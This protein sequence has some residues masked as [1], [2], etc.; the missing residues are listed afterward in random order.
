MNAKRF[1]LV[2]LLSS[3]AL[4]ANKQDAMN[5]RERAMDA[6]RGLNSSAILPNFNEHPKEQ[7]LETKQLKNLSINALP[8]NATAQDIYRN[9]GNHAARLSENSPE[10]RYAEQLLENPE[11]ALNGACYTKN[12]ECIE[13]VSDHSCFESIEYKKL[14]CADELK[15]SVQPISQTVT[16]TMSASP[17]NLESTIDLSHCPK[18]DWH[19]SA[20]NL[21]QFH[22]HCEAVDISV[23]TNNKPRVITQK[24]T[25]TEH[26]LK[27]K[28]SYWERQAQLTITLT[29][30]I[31][32]DEWLHRDCDKLQNQ[33][34][35]G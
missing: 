5:A 30:K 18:G 13:K 12:A 24:P 26:T 7:S 6:L 3:C 33:S 1:L 23:T 28:K 25:C 21:I 10:V 8:N 4:A 22:E 19:C 34:H 35:Q 17:Y 32:D 15:V 16:R 29:Q 20:A 31:S 14:S 9:A 11:E 27:I 2:G